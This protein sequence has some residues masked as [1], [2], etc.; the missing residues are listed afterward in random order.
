MTTLE[1]EDLIAAID[2]VLNR[3][4]HD[5]IEDNEGFHKE[6]RYEQVRREPERLLWE[7][8]WELEDK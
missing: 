2:R 8:K 6:H 5:T 7:L 4:E 1:K 3:I